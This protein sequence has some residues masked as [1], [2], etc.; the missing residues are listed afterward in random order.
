MCQP[1][2]WLLAA[3]IICTVGPSLTRAID[4]CV[5]PGQPAT[6]QF[7]TRVTI[8]G[9]NLLGAAGGTEIV[10]VT[11]A[12]EQAHIVSGISSSE[13]IVV[14][15]AGVRPQHPKAFYFNS[16]HDLWAS[17]TRSMATHN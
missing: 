1:V 2:R 4:V 15:P 13:V 14:A 10:E 6:G 8:Q 5:S 17:R 11:L 3:A 9:T 12:G 16:L 7:G